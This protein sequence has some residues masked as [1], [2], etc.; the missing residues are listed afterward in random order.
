MDIQ[1]KCI[2]HGKVIGWDS[3][4][5]I[6]FTSDTMP[7]SSG[8]PLMSRNENDIFAFGINSFQNSSNFIRYNF[9]QRIDEYMMNYIIYYINNY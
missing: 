2:L 4:N 3:F 6:Y 8:G 9:A 1:F 7:G 5:K